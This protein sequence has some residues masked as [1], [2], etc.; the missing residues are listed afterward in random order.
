VKFPVYV[1]LN[2]EKPIWFSDGR[3]TPNIL[4]HMP[5]CGFGAPVRIANLG[6]RLNR[7]AKPFER[8]LVGLET[9]NPRLKM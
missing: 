7:E 3:M 1:N 6:V 9:R 2:A 4:L 8:K 5:N